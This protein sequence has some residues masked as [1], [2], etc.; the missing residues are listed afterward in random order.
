MTEQEQQQC[1]QCRKR[2]LA[3]LDLIKQDM[4]ELQDAMHRQE[5]EGN[6]L[7]WQNVQLKQQLA[8]LNGESK[9]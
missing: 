7:A 5:K 2:T 3:S 9:G 4:V 1:E 6:F 8:A